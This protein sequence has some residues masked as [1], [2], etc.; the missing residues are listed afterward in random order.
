MKT[1]HSN[2]LNIFQ[3]QRILERSNDFHISLI[4]G[5]VTV[6]QE[7]ENEITIFL[8]IKLEKDNMK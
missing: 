4:Y 8:P 5:S 3:I 7:G 1:F 2:L 6:S